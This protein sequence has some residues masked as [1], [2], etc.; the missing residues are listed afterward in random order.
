M[1]T[2]SESIDTKQL[3][4]LKEKLEVLSSK[5]EEVEGNK[6]ARINQEELERQLNKQLN[7]L[8][9]NFPDLFGKYLGKAIKNQIRDSQDEVIDA[10]YPIIGK[11]ISRFIKAEIERISQKIDH[12]IKKPLSYKNLKLRFKAFMTGVSYEELL[13]RETAQSNLE[14]IFLIAKQGGMLLGHYS[15]DEIS[16]P[17]MIAGMLTGIKQFIEHAFERESQ[18]LNTLEYD[19]YTISIYNFKKFYFAAVIEGAL[20]AHFSN[21]LRES[22]FKFCET[23]TIFYEEAGLLDKKA[24]EKIS[25]S[26][27]DHFHGFNESGK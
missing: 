8:Q 24:V 27:R 10:L 14:E 7:F 21:R 20:H 9:E 22:I 2:P 3:L 5:L 19:K 12:H 15:S 4:E 23:N 18:E 16:H 11:L 25:E 1:D 17:D 6:D 26:L 13:V